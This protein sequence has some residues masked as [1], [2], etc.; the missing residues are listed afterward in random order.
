MKKREIAKVPYGTAE[1]TDQ[2]FRY[3]AIQQIIEIKGESHLFIEI[4]DNNEDGR[5]RP[6]LRMIFSKNDWCLY[7]VLEDIWLQGSFRN[8]Y[9]RNIWES[10]TAEK[11]SETFMSENDQDT[12]WDW[13]GEHG[14]LKR[15]C[16]SWTD[17][18]KHLIEDIRYDRRRKNTERRKQRLEDREAHTPPLPDNLEEWA[19][20]TLFRN[21]HFLY[22]KKHGNYVDVCCSKCGKVTT[23]RT[24]RRGSLEGAFE[25]AIDPP[26]NNLT[27]RCPSCGAFGTWKAQGRTKGVYGMGK[28]FFVGMPYK[29]TGAVIRYLECEKIYSM[30]ERIEEKKMIM[31]GASEKYAI[32]EIARMYFEKGKKKAQKDFHKYS[33]YSGENY[34]DDCNLSG[35]NNIVISEGKIYED[36]WRMLKGTV[37]QY[38]GGQQYQRKNSKFNLMD[39]MKCYWKYPQIEMFSKMGLYGVVE[40]MAKGYTWAIENKDASRPEW[41]LGINKDRIKLLIREKGNTGWLEAMK[42]EHRMEEHWT[43]EEL[44]FVKESG[45]VQ[46]DLELVLQHMSMRQLMNR[47]GKYSGLEITKGSVMC[48]RATQAI[49]TTSETYLDYLRMRIQRGYDLHNKIF[50]WPRDLRAAHDRMVEEINE[51]KIQKREQE[52]KEKFPGIRKSYRKLRN[53]YYYEDEEFLIR[54][55]RSAEEIV[56]EGRILH[57]CVGGDM[58]LKRHEARESTILFL[59]RKALPEEPYITIEISGTQI[60][61]WYGAYDRKPDKEVIEEWLKNYKR[62]L[63]IK[64]NMIAAAV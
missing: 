51:G 58:Y 55:A 45:L 7:Y 6:K 10:S 39:Y 21:E 41:F 19:D 4:F 25:Q 34:W 48:G 56:R 29:G 52:A 36:T 37:L 23:I 61:Q 43:E 15:E 31:T 49:R 40:S 20:K 1:E 32:V 14:Y 17:R 18:L 11:D 3:I 5:E 33:Y 13:C 27:G 28:N 42:I 12:I 64:E 62:S 9:G 47:I 26:Q 22:Y 60:R 24:C 57:H 16:A 35:M 54:P 59:R 50:L 46:P 2:Q 63:E 44:E 38:S 30:E 53:R 8:E